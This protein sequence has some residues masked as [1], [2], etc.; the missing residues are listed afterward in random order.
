MTSFHGRR[1]KHKLSTIGHEGTCPNIIAAEY[2][3]PVA[4]TRLN[5]ERL[6]AF[7]LRSGSGHNCPLFTTPI[8]HRSGGAS[9]SNQARKEIKPPTWKG[10]NTLAFACKYVILYIENPKD[11]PPPKNC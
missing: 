4:N 8:P 6:N 2:N 5:N 9:Q 10:R 1:K 11:P 7:P 3:K